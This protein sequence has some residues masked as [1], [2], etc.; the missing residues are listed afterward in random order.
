MYK[1][2]E[3]RNS[4]A[5]AMH[6]RSH[7]TVVDSPS[8]P[9]RHVVTSS[10]RRLPVSTPPN[11]MRSTRKFNGECK[12]F[13]IAIKEPCPKQEDGL[14]SRTL[15][16]LSCSKA[17]ITIS[18]A[19]RHIKVKRER[20]ANGNDE[21]NAKK[22]RISSPVSVSSV[23]HRAPRTAVIRT[24]LAASVA[25]SPTFCASPT[26]HSVCTVGPECLGLAASRPPGWPSR[27]AREHPGC[28]ALRFW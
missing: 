23:L 9:R 16:C 17:H 28:R 19:T 24:L 20:M 1:Y 5:F 22:R 15:R 6:A 27:R 14:P 3:F 12:G 13:G 7:A 25:A 11:M 4:D 8:S 21:N 18:Q 10:P 2:S 26:V